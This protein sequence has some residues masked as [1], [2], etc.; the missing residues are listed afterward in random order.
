MWCGGYADLECPK[1]YYCRKQE[2]FLYSTG[3]CMPTAGAV[4]RCG[5]STLETCPEGMSCVL[6][7]ANPGAPGTC[8][9]GA[10]L[11]D[12]RNY[13]FTGDYESK[14]IAVNDCGTGVYR[15]WQPSQPSYSYIDSAGKVLADCVSEQEDSTCMELNAKC[16]STANVCSAPS[17]GLRKC[18]KA[19]ECEGT[20][21]VCALMVNDDNS[22][23]WR[24]SPNE[25]SVCTD[26]FNLK[27]FKPGSCAETGALSYC[28]SGNA[29]CVSTRQK[30]C[31]LVSTA[32]G[33]YWKEFNDNCGACSAY[34]FVLGGTLNADGTLPEV[35]NVLGDVLIGYKTGNCAGTDALFSCPNFE[36]DPTTPVYSP[37]CGLTRIG[38][39][40][41]WRDYASSY[42]A[43]ANSTTG[44]AAGY[45][46]GYC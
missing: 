35:P 40:E 15:L 24:D 38:T 39:N 21:P 19:A 23:S 31:A 28:Q 4:I 12:P 20:M 34:R 32:S 30:V 6:N 10:G 25:C 29:S 2:A 33:S 11:R 5:G 44:I 7:P 9:S 37:S 36:T 42:A 3:M 41:K 45:R 46:Q 1:S 17:A 43:C 18:S 22:L 13:C 8:V 27:G 26:V 14:V 16:T